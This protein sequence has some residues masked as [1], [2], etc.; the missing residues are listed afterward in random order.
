MSII[1]IATA[2]RGFNSIAKQ[3]SRWI[4]HILGADYQQF[5]PHEHWRPSVNLYE[6]AQAYHLVADLAGLSIKDIQL[7]VEGGQLVLRGTRPSPRPPSHGKARL[8]PLRLHMMEIDHG[9][10]A[11]ALDLPTDADAGGVEAC[12]RNGFLWVTIPRK[13]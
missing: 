6:D 1:P 11:R 3:M 12:Y 9:P 13:A 5:R 10:F 2:D 4:D 8:C 7:H